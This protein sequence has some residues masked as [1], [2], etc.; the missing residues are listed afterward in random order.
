VDREPWTVKTRHCN[1]SRFTPHAPRSCPAV[2]GHVNGRDQS[3]SGRAGR[4]FGQTRGRAAGHSSYC[5][6]DK[7]MGIVSIKE[8]TEEFFTN[9][10]VT[11]TSCGI[12]GCIDPQ[13]NEG[14]IVIQLG[15]NNEENINAPTLL[16][17]GADT[18]R[19]FIKA[20]K[21]AASKVF[22]GETF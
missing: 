8:K 22:P 5:G 15:E 9:D 10:A 14:Q 12:S 13:S 1:A 21:M 6:K 4:V 7:A 17:A 2:A 19:E 3:V 16:I 18:I 11:T 20:I